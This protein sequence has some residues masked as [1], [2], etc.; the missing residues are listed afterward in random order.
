M[1]AMSLILT[2]NLFSQGCY[3]ADFE[4]GN[5]NGW[6]GKRGDCCPITLPNNGIT[7]GRQTIMS[8]GIDPNTCGGL[9]TVYSGNFSARLGNDNVGAQAEGLTF[10]FTV[11]P[12]STLVQYAY[13]V[14]FE[15]P[16]HTDDEQPRFNSRVRLPDGSIIACTDYMVTAASN[17][18]G[19]QSCPGIDAQGDPVNIAWRDWSTV[20][21]DLTAYVGQTV[22]LEFETGDCSLGGHFGYAYI[23]AIYCTANEIDVQ[24]CINQTTAILS[25]PPGFTS[26]L[27]ETGE[28]TQ[29][30]SVNPALY[31]TLS[32]FL[33]TAT[34]CELTLTAALQPTVPTPSFTYIGEC[35]GIFN[36]TN[37]S[38]IS[39]NG[40]GTYLWNFGD[41]TTS[42]LF[43][44]SHTYLTPGVYTVT[45]TIITDN[46]CS[47]QIYQNIQVY[48]IPS[49]SFISSDN[50]FGNPT[51]FINTTIPELGYTMD[52]LWLFGNNITSV[53]QSPIYT[54]TNY[55][56]Y[57]VELIVGIQGTNCKDTLTD[58]VN[59]RQNPIASFISQ[60]SCQG[61]TTQFLNNSQVPSWSISNQYLWSFGEFGSTSL[62]SNPTYTYSS[63]GT[64]NVSLLVLSTDGSLSCSS[65]I[66]NPVIIYPNPVSNFIAPISGCVNESISFTNLSTISST[67]QI[68]NY[69]WNFG[70]NITSNIPNSSH[71]YTSPGVYNI[72][73]TV[74]SNFGCV[75]T[76]QKQITINPLPTVSFSPNSGSGCPPLSLDFTDLSSGLIN[77]WNWSFGDGQF[78]NQQNPTHTYSESGVYQVTLQVTSIEGCTTISNSPVIILVHPTPIASFNVNPT[79]V[80][81]YNPIVNFTNYSSGASNYI[82]NFGDGTYSILSNP[83]HSYNFYGN[84]IIS[85]LAENQF[86]CLDSS[87][88]QVNVTP[89]FTF[90]IP[91]AFTPSKDHK[92]EIFFG[93]GVNYKSVTMQIFNRWGEKIFDKT[94]SEPPIWDGT[95]NGVD[96]QIDVYVYQFFVTDI[97]DVVHVYRGRVS[98][99]R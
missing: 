65:N 54:Y 21:V 18:S 62:L 69:V 88:D 11:T 16:G 14:V 27:W 48:P 73:L 66:N 34:G 55:G 71:I 19:F 91:N 86:G 32:C 80:D 95:L 82:W 79:E 44:T 93:K 13:A 78:S 2:L 10:T 57:N 90:Y 35:Q 52:Y 46:G 33:T 70:D 37:T 9:S 12:Q 59:I 25:A 5:F 83:Q 85:L 30:I 58:V 67:S 3:N 94:S 84:F 49:A 40:Q 75:G 43:N 45:L 29:T 26:Y 15:D 4:L 64:Y 92:N 41:N 60:N 87:F 72:T 20:T 22:T 50:C 51:S 53:S 96:C 97:S 74:T 6:Q 56:T 38:T 24:Y 23:D 7:N 76:F 98:L 17:L 36:F 39:N 31:N 68:I 8:P 61:I 89:I 42:T 1:L 63:D 99:V 47:D 77:Y 81:E 28:T